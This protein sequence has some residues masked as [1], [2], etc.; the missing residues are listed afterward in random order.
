METRSTCNVRTH[1]TPVIGGYHVESKPVHI[2]LRNVSSFSVTRDLTLNIVK[3]SLSLCC[4]W[5]RV[6]GIF[7]VRYWPGLVMSDDQTPGADH[8][9]VPADSGP[10]QLTTQ[11]NGITWHKQRLSPPTTT[12]RPSGILERPPLD[13]L[14][15]NGLMKT[16]IFTGWMD[17]WWTSILNSLNWTI[18][19]GFVESRD[20]VFILFL[21]IFRLTWCLLRCWASIF[22][23]FIGIKL[24]VNR[25]AL[26]S[27]CLKHK[28]SLDKEKVGN[29]GQIFNATRVIDISIRSVEQQL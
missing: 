27:T 8:C 17:I 22:R 7:S 14:I 19:L 2:S 12:Q 16:L 9:R 5:P 6:W 15:F 26:S 13:S 4:S 20:P 21:R 1:N 25:L 18:S 10:S 24:D 23:K 28:L 11:D 29:G 3:L